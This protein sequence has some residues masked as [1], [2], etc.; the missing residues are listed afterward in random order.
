[1]WLRCHIFVISLVGNITTTIKYLQYP[2]L[3]NNNNK[4]I[5][6][7]IFLSLAVLPVSSRQ[8]SNR[9]ENRGSDRMDAILLL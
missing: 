8:P 4:K 7:I 9:E 3:N 2:N 6:K 1:M 5:T